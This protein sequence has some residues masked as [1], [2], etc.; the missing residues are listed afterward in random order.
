MAPRWRSRLLLVKECLRFCP[1]EKVNV[2]AQA[3]LIKADSLLSGL[4]TS[5]ASGVS[6]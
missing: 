4:V 3:R 6:L 5:V 1:K 2:W